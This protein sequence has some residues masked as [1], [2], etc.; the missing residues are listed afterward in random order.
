MINLK[1]QY[2]NF[3]DEAKEA[4]CFFHLNKNEIS[5]LELKYGGVKRQL[6]SLQANN[7][8]SGL[9]NFI[10][11]IVITAY[12]ERRGDAFVKTPEIVENYRYG[13][14]HSEVMVQILSKEEGKGLTEFI[15]GCMSAENRKHILEEAK[16]DPK[17]APL[18][19]VECSE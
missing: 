3:D 19:D 14:A 11:D 10:E 5:K 8:L 6:D 18:L 15:M 12:G 2:T 1:I 4:S 7:D 9:Y 13:A 16:K 17:L